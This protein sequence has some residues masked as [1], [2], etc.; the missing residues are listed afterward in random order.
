MN[1]TAHKGHHAPRAGNKKEKK[2]KGKGSHDRGFNEKA[3]LIRNT[4]RVFHGSPMNKFTLNRLLRRNPGVMLTG[5]VD[6]KPS[7]TRLDYMCH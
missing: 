3:R 7:K 1:D 5:K 4:G 2:E 6:V